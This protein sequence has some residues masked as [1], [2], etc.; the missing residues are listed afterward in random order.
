MIKEQQENCKGDIAG[1]NNT[2]SATGLAA[3]P[4]HTPVAI[5]VLAEK[6]DTVYPRAE[7]I[8]NIGQNDLDDTELCKKDIIIPE[9]G[10]LNSGRKPTNSPGSDETV[11]DD[12]ESTKD[13]LSDD[14]ARTD[15]STSVTKPFLS[16]ET[17]INIC[18]S[19]SGNKIT[20]WLKLCNLRLGHTAESNRKII[21]DFLSRAAEGK[22]KL[23]PVLVEKLVSRLKIEAVT[24][25]LTNIGIDVPKNAAKRKS[26]LAIYLTTEF[27]TLNMKDYY[28]TCDLERSRL[29]TNKS[30]LKGFKRSHKVKAPKSKK[31]SKARKTKSVSDKPVEQSPENYKPGPSPGNETSKTSVVMGPVNETA[32]IEMV[33]VI[34]DPAIKVTEECEKE[35]KKKTLAEG[36]NEVPAAKDLNPDDAANTRTK[37][38]SKKKDATETVHTR[39]KSKDPLKGMDENSGKKLEGNPDKRPNNDSV[40]KAKRKDILEKMNDKPGKGTT[41][42]TERGNNKEEP[43]AKMKK[44]KLDIISPQGGHK[45]DASVA[46]P[47]K[48]TSDKNKEAIDPKGKKKQNR[49]ETTPQEPDTEKD[50][51]PPSSADKNNNPRDFEKPLRTLEASLLK[52]QDNINTQGEQITLLSAKVVDPDRIP[53]KSSHNADLLDLRSKVDTLLKTIEVQQETLLQLTES[54]ESLKQNY[55]AVSCNPYNTLLRPCPDCQECKEEI[56]ELKATVS[57]LLNDFSALKRNAEKLCPCSEKAQRMI[58]H[59]EHS[60]CKFPTNMQI[61]SDRRSQAPE[62]EVNFGNVVSCHEIEVGQ[63]V[64]LET[65][66][67]QCPSSFPQGVADT[68]S[69]CFVVQDGK[70][71]SADKKNLGAKYIIEY[72][73]VSSLKKALDS[74]QSIQERIQKAAPEMVF[75]NLGMSEVREASNS[76]PQFPIK[77]FRRLVTKCAE[78]LRS[79]S[80]I[81]IASLPLTKKNRSLNDRITNF[82]NGITKMT[83]NLNLD[84]ELTHA[85]QMHP[86]SNEDNEFSSVGRSNSWKLQDKGN[87]NEVIGIGNSA[88]TRP[89]PV[90]KGNRTRSTLPTEEGTETQGRQGIPPERTQMNTQVDH[91]TGQPRVQ[92]SRPDRSCLDKGMSTAPVQGRTV[93]YPH[94]Y[95]KQWGWQ[96][97][98]WDQD[99][100]HKKD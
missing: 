3:Q 10:C 86:Q 100:R 74:I 21:L 69:K 29:G 88:D 5:E 64:T 2:K 73:Q 19:N 43:K 40:A 97:T 12:S 13:L 33:G 26:A 52:L 35:D 51:H 42:A 15:P 54:K 87:Q 71:N 58:V 66:S 50:L 94:T 63:H 92:E 48:L 49:K 60:Y 37:K 80:K 98:C 67:T 81:V 82:N 39:S 84:I 20:D 38:K 45:S 68:R 11:V 41:T 8:N 77:I 23:P 72:L 36:I 44:A 9:N 62:T 16:K 22:A 89:I 65:C 79:G 76:A 57:S 28:E 78:P 83:S 95:V 47:E 93:S 61:E 91:D 1:E 55:H 46:R 59:Q 53:A 7:E 24:T 99:Q 6:L 56:S 75:L 31:K 30:Y 90:L 25:E 18:N 27:S 34:S 85:E 17:I 96:G 4:V 32:E 14:T 70:L